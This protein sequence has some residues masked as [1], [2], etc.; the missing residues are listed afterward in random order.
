[1]KCLILSAVIIVCCSVINAQT[2]DRI[3]F[4]S[5][6]GGDAFCQFSVGGT[7]GCVLYGENGSLTI[8]SEYMDETNSANDS[9]PGEDDGLREQIALGE[10]ISVYPNPV[11]Y[12]VNVSIRDVGCAVVGSSLE[13]YD[14]GGVLVLSRAI[15]ECGSEFPVDLSQLAVGTYIMKIGNAK[16]KIV[17]R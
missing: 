8:T 5:Q 2:L 12:V 13:I 16:A 6:S 4:Y 1:M 7:F 14:M 15:T 3:G 17:K 11:E 10:G 9:V